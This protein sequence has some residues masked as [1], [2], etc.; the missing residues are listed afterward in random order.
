MKAI[1]KKTSSAVDTVK[2]E[3][4]NDLFS[5]KYLPDEKLVESDLARYYGVSRNTIREAFSYFITNGILVKE[6]NK[7]VHV[8]R[9]TVEDIREIFHLRCLLEV[10]AITML[11]AMDTFPDT[12]TEALESV[13]SLEE[14]GNRV[15]ALHAD[16]H[17]HRLLVQETG[18]DRLIRLYQSILYEVRMCLAQS[19]YL[20]PVRR[21]KISQHRKILE[22]I[23]QKNTTMAKQMLCRHMNQAINNYERAYMSLQHAGTTCPKRNEP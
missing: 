19:N 3:L 9:I 11:T 20:V 12:L 4:E 18:S 22:A 21:A 16:I 8:R 15:Q 17:L 13:E 10:E 6:I 2:M 7:G 14:K 23:K 1:S 5:L